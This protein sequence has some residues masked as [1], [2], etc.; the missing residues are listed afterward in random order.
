MITSTAQ[1]KRTIYLVFFFIP[2]L[3]RFL[4]CRCAF[5]FPPV[6]VKRHKKNK[7]WTSHTLRKRLGRRYTQWLGHKKRPRNRA[8]FGLSGSRH[9]HTHTHAT[10]LPIIVD[11][12]VS[13]SFLPC[14]TAVNGASLSLFSLA[15]LTVCFLSLSNALFRCL[16]LLFPPKPPLYMDAFGQRRLRSCRGLIFRGAVACFFATFSGRHA[17][18]NLFFL[19]LFCFCA[20]LHT[21]MPTLTARSSNLTYHPWKCVVRPAK[22][23]QREKGLRKR[24]YL[25]AC[26]FLR[27]FRLFT[28]QRNGT[29]KNPAYVKQRFVEYI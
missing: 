22:E 7:N 12:W 26:S 6:D 8:P 10:G 28:R 29:K 9:A 4:H 3:T 17:T 23:R 1:Q 14:E 24:R 19:L 25:Q 20:P 15:R 16:T 18:Q 5:P 11:E 21:R 13:F 27:E 2:P